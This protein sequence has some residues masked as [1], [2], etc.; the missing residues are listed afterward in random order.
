VEHDWLAHFFD[1]CR[2]VSDAE[3]QSLWGRVLAEESNRPATFSKRTV[4]LITT[5]DKA[6]A[7]LFTKFCTFV[8]MIGRPIPVILDTREPLYQKQDIT[9]QTMV[10]LDSI[11]LIR[12]DNLGGF[13]VERLHKIVTVFYHGKPVNVEFQNESN[14]SLQIG[15]ALLTVAGEQLARICSATPSGEYF[16][17]ILNKWILGSYVLSSPLPVPQQPA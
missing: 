8:W 12:F 7:L 2:L 3:M 9:F 16:E 1:R 13:T 4:D 6:D 10:H 15:K 14:N 5:L 11:G 17:Y